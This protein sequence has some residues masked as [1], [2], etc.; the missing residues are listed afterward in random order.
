MDL[1][2]Q[3]IEFFLDHRVDIACVVKQT[4]DLRRLRTWLVG[5]K[6]LS[7]PLYGCLVNGELTWFQQ[8][9]LL[10]EQVLLDRTGV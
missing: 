3:G 7:D 4:K 6:Q 2:S 10:Q 9:R 1:D 5:I 8:A